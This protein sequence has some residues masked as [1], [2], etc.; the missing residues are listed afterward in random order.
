MTKEEK[1][2]Y[3]RI[4]RKNNKDKKKKQDR[5]YALRNPDR[6]KKHKDKW[7][8]ANLEQHNKNN[9]IWHENN[10]EEVSKKHKKIYEENKE[11][12]ILRT[13]IRREEFPEK[14]MANTAFSNAIKKGKIVRNETCE[15]CDKKCK[16]E[17]HHWS[18]AEQNQLNVIWVCIKCHKNIHAIGLGE[19]EDVN[20]IKNELVKKERI[21]GHISSIEEPVSDLQHNGS[22]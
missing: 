9:R 8:K 6:V 5:E 11:K 18:Y 4:Y 7:R 1:K 10:K 22:N 16:T 15:I 12:Y 3:D 2:E 14:Y 20:T 13:L 19:I 17:G 21:N